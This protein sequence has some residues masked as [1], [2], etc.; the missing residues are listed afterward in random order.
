MEFNFE[1]LNVW[2]EAAEF[3]ANMLQE[4][5]KISPQKQPEITSNL[6]RASLEIPSCLAKGKAYYNGQD[7]LPWLHNRAKES[8]FEV[9]SLLKM[10]ESLNLIEPESSNDLLESANKIIAQMIAL[11]KSIEK[12]AQE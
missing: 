3:A 5:E 7:F 9:A 8:I 12:R 1:K 11:S 6:K 10:S 4:V 2:Q